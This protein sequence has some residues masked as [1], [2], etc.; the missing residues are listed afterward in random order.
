MKVTRDS[1]NRNEAIRLIWDQT[2]PDFK[3]K[4]DGKPSI[5]L[6]AA[7]GGGLSTIDGLNDVVF[8]R[9]AKNAIDSKN[10]QTCK[11][12]TVQI[13]SKHK[14][15]FEPLGLLDKNCGTINQW[16]G[17]FQGI[18][19]LVVGLSTKG[20][21]HYSEDKANE[22]LKTVEHFEGVYNRTSEP[23]STLSR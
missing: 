1:L 23:S 18:K 7:D 19:D 3:G 14:D 5:M 10:R 20:D 2:S 22:I 11:D 17:D 16:C 9:Y 6:A 12:L 13:F 8:E 15:I 4:L 21:G